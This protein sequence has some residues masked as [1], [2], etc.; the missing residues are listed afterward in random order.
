MLELATRQPSEIG[1]VEHFCDFR[2]VHTPPSPRDRQHRRSGRWVEHKTRFGPHEWLAGRRED[3]HSIHLPEVLGFP[4]VG[5][6]SAG[7]IL[8]HTESSQ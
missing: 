3:V 6:G 8:F 7:L 1:W 2:G 4:A 5:R